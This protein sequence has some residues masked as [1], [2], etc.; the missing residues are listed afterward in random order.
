MNTIDRLLDMMSGQ[1]L[2]TTAMPTWTTISTPQKIQNTT[3]ELRILPDTPNGP[4]LE[5]VTQSAEGVELFKQRLNLAAVDDLIG[6]LIKM[7]DLMAVMKGPA[8][9]A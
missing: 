2:W 8:D 9:E 7:R 4:M 5:M 3:E 1:S 6:K